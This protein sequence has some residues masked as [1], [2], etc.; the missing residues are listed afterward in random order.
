MAHSYKYLDGIYF[1][2]LLF[3]VFLIF[4][5]AHVCSAVELAWI[6]IF[7]F[8]L[9]FLSFWYGLLGHYK[10]MYKN[11][12][13]V[14]FACVACD[15]EMVLSGAVAVVCLWDKEY[16]TEVCGFIFAVVCLFQIL[17]NLGWGARTIEYSL[18]FAVFD[19]SNFTEN[20]NQFNFNMRN[21]W[22]LVRLAWQLKDNRTNKIS[23]CDK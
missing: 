15:V 5:V 10:R 21:D 3:V 2:S 6:F 7:E 8:S 18:C 19:A 9:S 1:I 13:L 12:H 11:I 20:G 23:A 17:A 22:I 14:E 16:W 4:F